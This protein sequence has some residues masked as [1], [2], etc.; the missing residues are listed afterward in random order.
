MSAPVTAEDIQVVSALATL[1]GIQRIGI[2]L[3]AS[4]SELPPH[5]RVAWLFWTPVG[6]GPTSAKATVGKPTASAEKVA[7]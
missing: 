3:D 6:K 4:P 1:V 5:A 2:N 7:A